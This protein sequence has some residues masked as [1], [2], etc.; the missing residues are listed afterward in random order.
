MGQRRTA[1]SDD[2]RAFIQ[3]SIN[4][5]ALTTR[6]L[7][8]TA[9]YALDLEELTGHNWGRL[10]YSIGGLWSTAIL[11]LAV[12]TGPLF[13]IGLWIGSKLFG[14]ASDEL[15]RRICYALIAVSAVIGLPLFDGILH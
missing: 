3:G 5:A 6:G 15:F 2:D 13:G 10:N 7:D 4:Y 11:G 12:I 8:F 9:R 14:K 1:F